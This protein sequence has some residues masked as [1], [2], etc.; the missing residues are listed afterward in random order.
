[1]IDNMIV[2]DRLKNTAKIIR[3]LRKD[4]K[5][6]LCIGCRIDFFRSQYIKNYDYNI[7]YIPYYPLNNDID[8]SQYDFIFIY[9]KS[10]IKDLSEF[11]NKIN[12]IEY[13]ICNNILEDKVLNEVVTKSKY[14]DRGFVYSSVGDIFSDNGK[15]YIQVN[16]GENGLVLYGPY[17]TLE[18]GDYTVVFTFKDYP[19]FENS[20]EINICKC[21]VEITEDSIILAEREITSKDLSYD[22]EVIIN[23]SLQESK[24]IEFKCYSHGNI[25]F[26]LQAET[27]LRNN[28]KL[29]KNQGISQNS[30]SQTGED[31]I[32]DYV[33]REIIKEPIKYYFDIGANFPEKLSNTYYFYKKYNAKGVC[34]EANPDLAKDFILKRERDTVLNVGLVSNEMVKNGCNLEFYILDGDGLSSFEKANVDKYIEAGNAKLLDVIKIPTITINELFDKYYNNGVDFVNMD[35]EGLELS[36]LKDLDFDIYRPKVF[37]IET[38]VNDGKGNF[39]K[40]KRVEEFLV[41]KGYKVIADTVVNTIFIDNKYW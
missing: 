8:F 39:S 4:Y 38:I 34:I 18:P 21:Y 9:H 26:I 23:F 30:Y 3:E 28:L 27:Q 13:C 22:N 32:I 11:L 16:W 33:F 37:C 40:D 19:P 10:F 7:S 2:I 35:I 36:I 24:E 14:V 29:G 20:E 31:T 41:T 12:N 1:M 6:I 5:N 25:P 17:V 15:Y